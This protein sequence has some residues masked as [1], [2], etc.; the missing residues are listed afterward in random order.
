LKGFIYKHFSF[1]KD[2]IDVS[3]KLWQTCTYQY[4][5]FTGYHRKW[6]HG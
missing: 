6:C 3:V 4:Y 5:R 1:N 2:D